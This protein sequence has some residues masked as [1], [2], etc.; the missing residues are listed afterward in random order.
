[1]KDP[2]GPMR[3]RRIQHLVSCIPLVPHCS[4]GAHPAMIGNA[5]GTGLHS[6]TKGC[7]RQRNRGDRNRC[8]T[9]TLV[10]SKHCSSGS[11]RFDGQRNRVNSHPKQPNMSIPR[12]GQTMLPKGFEPTVYGKLPGKPASQHPRAGTANCTSEQNAGWWWQRN[13]SRPRGYQ[14]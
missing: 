2:T 3:E 9:L 5:C 11:R 7:T 12:I 6:Q 4:T 13:G 10:L 14:F 8:Q 1:M